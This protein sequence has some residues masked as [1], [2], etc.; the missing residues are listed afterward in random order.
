MGGVYVE[1][2]GLMCKFDQGVLS[3]GVESMFRI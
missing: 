1:L 2:L 3:K